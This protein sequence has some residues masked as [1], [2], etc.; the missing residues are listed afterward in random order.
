MNKRIRYGKPRHVTDFRLW[1]AGASRYIT[2]LSILVIA[3]VA[4]MLATAKLPQASG[5]TPNKPANAI[6]TLPV[7]RSGLNPAQETVAADSSGG[8]ANDDGSIL[9]NFVP[10]TNTV[11]NDSGAASAVNSSRGMLTYTVQSGDTLF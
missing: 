6:R 4:V 8:T 1:I 11:S 3:I 7:K 9:R 10:M 5:S 2:H